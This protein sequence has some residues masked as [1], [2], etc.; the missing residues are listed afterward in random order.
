MI[1]TKIK[2]FLGMLRDET[3]KTK[4]DSRTIVIMDEFAKVDKGYD[5]SGIIVVKTNK[6]NALIQCWNCK[7]EMWVLRGSRCYVEGL[8]SRCLVKGIR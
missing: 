5:S 8:C 2:K 7:K 4:G 1:L 6:K 3:C